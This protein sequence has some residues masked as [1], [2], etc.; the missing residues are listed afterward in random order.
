MRTPSREIPPAAQLFASDRRFKLWRYGVGHSQ[1]LLRS[2]PTGDQ[3]C[4]DILFEGVRW[5][6]LPMSFESL[7][8]SRA[9][10]PDEL[11]RKAGLPDDMGA[12]ALELTGSGGAGHLVCGRATAAYTPWTVTSTGPE[13]A[14][15]EILWT[16]SP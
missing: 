15:T 12:L 4:L 2:L 7:V 5:I 9:G 13:A 10:A 1:L 8:I 11:L 14:P 6:E 3:P 16:E